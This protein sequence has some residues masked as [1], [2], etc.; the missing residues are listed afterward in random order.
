[1]KFKNPEYMLNKVSFRSYRRKPHQKMLI[2]TISIAFLNFQ[3]LPVHF[4]GVA[5]ANNTNGHNFGNIKASD[6][7]LGTH[8]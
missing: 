5:G 1:M 2:R 7:K 8:T 3:Y 6:L 4:F